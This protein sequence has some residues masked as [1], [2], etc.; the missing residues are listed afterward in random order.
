MRL[1]QCDSLQ[2]Q[3]SGY[4]YVWI[5][6]CCIDKSS[7]AELTE[8]INSMYAWYARSRKC[9]AYLGDF[10]LSTRSHLTPHADFLSKLIAPSDVEF[11]DLSWNN[12]DSNSN[13][14]EDIAYATETQPAE[15]IAYCLLGIFG[16][17][18]ALIR[19]QQEII[20]L[21][22]NLANLLG[23]RETST[24]YRITLVF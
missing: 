9:F 17:A 16:G 1:I 11:Y 3:E 19:L 24:S 13:L 7:S 14:C 8:A 15:D 12:Y 23:G 6:T 18:R 5:D 21:T 22:K 10:D 4:S 2:L 20:K